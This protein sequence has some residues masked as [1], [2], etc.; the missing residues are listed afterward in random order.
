MKEPA[1]ILNIKTPYQ[2]LL[3]LEMAVHCILG[4]LE[5]IE[6][7]SVPSIAIAV[8]MEVN[9]VCMEE[10]FLIDLTGVVVETTMLIP[11]YA[12]LLPQKTAMIFHVEQK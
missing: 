9:D 12:S 1:Q 5:G 8:E 3:Q 4:N 7:L 6:V 2:R 10:E 11:P